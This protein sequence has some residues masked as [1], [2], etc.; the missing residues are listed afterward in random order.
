MGPHAVQVENAQ[1]YRLHDFRR[2]HAMDL[3]NKG[4][5]LGLILKAGEWR[6]PAFLLYFDLQQLETASVVEAHLDES[7]GDDDDHARAPVIA[8]VNTA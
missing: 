6:S 8:I 1:E 3:L 7:S 2:G 4:A 5:R